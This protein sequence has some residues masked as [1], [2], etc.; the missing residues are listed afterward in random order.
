METFTERLKF[1]INQ[2]AKTDQE[3][4]DKINEKPSTVSGWTTGRSFPSLKG[5]KSILENYPMLSADWLILGTGKSGLM[6]EYAEN[7]MISTLNESDIVSINDKIFELLKVMDNKITEI[8]IQI[9]QKK[10]E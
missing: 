1:L 5:I 10:S 6:N 2:V 3:F 8:K 9:E 4:S 7:D